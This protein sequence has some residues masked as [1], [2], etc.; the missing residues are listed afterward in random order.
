[1]LA[2]TALVAA[3]FLIYERAN[4]KRNVYKAIADDIFRDYN[5]KIIIVDDFWTHQ[6]TEKMAV[7]AKGIASEQEKR[8]FIDECVNRILSVRFQA[9][10]VCMTTR[11]LRNFQ[12]GMLFFLLGVAG[13]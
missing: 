2:A 9:E 10:N 5:S 12:M 6:Y 13:T 8:I 4:G 7:V 11:V 3:T 1:M